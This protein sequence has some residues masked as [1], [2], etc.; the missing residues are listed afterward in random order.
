MSIAAYVDLLSRYGASAIRL[1]PVEGEP[2]DF[3][4][5]GGSLERSFDELGQQELVGVLRDPR[6]AA[7][8][9]GDGQLEV[10]AVREGAGG[11]LHVRFAGQTV[12]DEP[13]EIPPLQVASTGARF[14]PD[15]QSEASVDLLLDPTVPLYAVSDLG[16]TLRWFRS[17]QHGPGIGEAVLRG[18]IPAIDPS[19]LGDAAFRA[20]HG[21]KWS[22][23]AG[24]MAGGIASVELVTT[25][26]KAGLLSFFGSGGLPVE[27]TERAVKTL[28]SSI[29][30]LPFGF[31]LL[32]NPVEPAVEEKTVDLYIEH[33]IHRAEASAFMGLTAA[34]VRYRLHGI[35]DDGSGGIRCPNR[36]MA[37]VSRP[38]VAEKFLRPAPPE[39]IATLVKRG[40]LTD[41][42]A[43]LARRIP[44]ADDITAEADSGGHTDHRPLVVLVPSLMQLRDRIMRE[45]G[46]AS[47]GIRPR[48]G[49]AGGL[50]TPKGIHAA[51]AIG[52]DYVLT[53]SVNQ[54]S[55]EAGTSAVAKQMLSE[56]SW[57]EVATGPAPDMFEIGAKVQVLGRGTMYA[58]R[59]QKLYDL[60][61][62]YASMEEI[63]AKEMEKV[64]KQFFRRPVADVWEDTR[65]YWTD[66][67]PKQIE[68]AETDPRHKMALSFRWY[69]G[70]T[71]RWAR[72]GDEE[73]KRDYQMWCGP[74][75]GAFNEWAKGTDLAP[76]EGRSVVSIA[77]A[78]MR[79]ATIEARIHLARTLGLPVSA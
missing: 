1:V 18:A 56:A 20:A 67:D 70:M 24:A 34:V 59:A 30:D 8:T 28:S 72:A 36:V 51:F 48:V 32:H 40:V 64:E 66:R 57:W 41:Q 76:L 55:R 46:Y 78:L 61:R 31:N 10:T 7:V 62:T 21:V 52:A 37:K 25:M 68:R 69:L 77:T 60:Y 73:R 11:R 50:G 39:M 3:V 4:A 49:A 13:V 38:E 17:G 58:Q 15:P 42:Q 26:A 74:A 43:L 33:G 5:P 9:L 79:G 35:E 54:S 2:E 23:V 45:E 22:Y 63:P 19:E 27:V 12:V 71:S 47:L 44:I 65:R 6:I 75:M 16:G 14:R 53:G 29:S